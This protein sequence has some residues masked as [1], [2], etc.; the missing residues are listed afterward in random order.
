MKNKP[1]AGT[2]LTFTTGGVTQRRYVYTILSYR[3][4]R[5]GIV[6]VGDDSRGEKIGGRIYFHGNI[7]RIFMQAGRNQ[8]GAI[9]Y[10]QQVSQFRNQLTLAN[11]VVTKD[12]S[13]S[14]IGARHSRQDEIS[15]HIFSSPLVPKE[16]PLS[17]SG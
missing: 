2:S 16:A 1:I 4:Q 8:G 12:S 15:R 13:H 9:L 5:P 10:V 3:E 6:N 11:I 7:N 17:R 14:M